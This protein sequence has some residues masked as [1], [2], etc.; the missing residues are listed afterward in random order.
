MEVARASA[1][2][3]EMDPMTEHAMPA[4]MPIVPAY[5]P[6]PA[7]TAMKVFTAPVPAATAPAFI[8]PTIAVSAVPIVFGLYIA[9]DGGRSCDFAAHP[10]LSVKLAAL[11]KHER[12]SLPDRGAVYRDA[13]AIRVGDR[14]HVPPILEWLQFPDLMIATIA[15]GD[16]DR[17]AGAWRLIGRPRQAIEAKPATREVAAILVTEDLAGF[18]SA[19][20]HR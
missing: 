15:F 20:G 17:I 3:A 5:G 9:S 12:G 18:S 2:T 13:Q 6:A 11:C 19:V 7:D 1:M 8:V 10:A 14:H 4:V 16:A